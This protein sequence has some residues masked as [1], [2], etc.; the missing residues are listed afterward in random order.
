MPASLGSRFFRQALVAGGVGS[1]AIGLASFGVMNHQFKMI[2]EQEIAASSARTNTLVYSLRDNSR[3][4]LADWANWDDAYDFISGKNPSFLM[5]YVNAKVIA[6]AGADAIAV[7]ADDGSIRALSLIHETPALKQAW[8]GIAA[9]SALKNRISRNGEP[10]AGFEMINGRLFVVSASAIRRTDHSGVPKGILIMGRE[11]TA[12]E[13]SSALQ[14]PVRFGRSIGVEPSL[15]NGR[16]TIELPLPQLLDGKDLSLFVDVDLPATE[17]ARIQEI[18]Q[19]L[20]LVLLSVLTA[21]AMLKLIERLVTSRIVQLERQVEDLAKDDFRGRLPEDAGTDEISS[22]VR[23]FN[24]LLEQVDWRN[25]E[26]RRLRKE[27]QNALEIAVRAERAKANFVAVTSHEIRNPLAAV[28]GGIELLQTLDLPPRVAAIA[29][30][31]ENSGER[32]RAIV[33]DILDFSR[34]EHEGVPISLQPIDL[35]DTIGQIVDSYVP[36]AAAKGLALDF[37]SAIPAKEYV[38]TDPFRIQQVLGNLI[39][40]AIKFTDEGA[41]VVRLDRTEEWLVRVA[42]QDTGV[43]IN[44]AQADHLFRPFSQADQSTVRRFGGTGLGLSI[45]KRI[46]EAMGGE[47]GMTS[48]PGL[49]STF[50]FQLALPPAEKRFEAA[51]QQPS[52]PATVATVTPRLSVLVVEDNQ[53]VQAVI[54]DQLAALGHQVTCVANGLAAFNAVSQ[55]AFDAVLMDMHMPV[56][57]GLTAARAIRELGAPRGDLPIIALTADADQSRRKRYESA[58]FDAFLT[59]PCNGAALAD[60]LKDCEQRPPLK[61]G[62]RSAPALDTAFIAEI[63]Q[64]MGSAALARYLRQF[65]LQLAPAVADI[66]SVDGPDAAGELAS[67]A[68]SLKG[69]ASFIGAER[70]HNI[71]QSI[72]RLARTGGN[73]QALKD[74]LV[75]AASDLRIIIDA[76]AQ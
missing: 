45:C 35:V 63:D 76:L 41:I 56:M 70:L 72:E 34:I 49:G 53:M 69:A 3:S 52:P 51:L 21:I 62:R 47:I 39:G 9:S 73:W 26:E 13:L 11:V 60:A 12:L 27:A 40:N 19:P 71:L 29:R 57:D 46:V 38:L 66:L 20:W 5:K 67:Q 2:S 8:A 68:H 48:K 54:Q 6:D 10:A 65:N 74:D 1:I 31:L 14:A 7:V 44:P 32:L 22:L 15:S 28:L 25:Q 50:W 16:A 17:S 4:P 33:D 61:A 55:T 59:K 58:G 23:R 75:E 64:G 36:Q 43:G 42:V 24:L 37:R 18:V 30:R